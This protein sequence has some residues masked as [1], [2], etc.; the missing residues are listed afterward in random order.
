MPGGL[1]NTES[2]DLDCCGN[3]ESGTKI[4]IIIIIKLMCDSN[5]AFCT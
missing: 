1:H 3:K 4:I 2:S 5:K